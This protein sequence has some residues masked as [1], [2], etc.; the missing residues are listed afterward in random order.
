MTQLFWSHI[1]HSLS[2]FNLAEIKYFKA[3][4]Y[5]VLYIVKVDQVGGGEELFA[6]YGF[7]SPDLVKM[8]SSL[9]L[10]DL[11]LAS[12]AGNFL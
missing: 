10:I 12:S 11:E 4:K 3:S 9:N 6:D 1:N 2:K 8:Y 5:R 7:D